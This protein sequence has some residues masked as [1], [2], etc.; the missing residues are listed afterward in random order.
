MCRFVLYQG[1]PLTIAS[2]VTEPANSI[3]NQSVHSKESEEPLNGDGFGVAWWA[4]ELSHKPAVFRSV[5]PAWSNM[6]LLELA[7][8]TRSGSIL[9]HVRA[10]TRGL[11]VT[12]LNCHPFAA[13]PYAFMHNGDVAR[14]GAIRRRVLAD[15]SDDSFHAVKGSTDSEHLFGVFL[16]QVAKAGGTPAAATAGKVKA[17]PGQ[18]AEAM[19][20]GLERTIEYIT[21][22]SKNAAP[23]TKRDDAAADE[24]EDC[25]LNIAVSDGEHAVACRYTTATTDPSSLYVHTGRRYVCEGGLCRMVSPE[26]GHG[27]VIVSSEPLS[28]DPGWQKIP[29]NHM[30]VVGQDRTCEIRAMSVA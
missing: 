24:E 1:V 16:D 12:E 6:N 9:A 11:P 27:A 30:V 4:P 26:K 7:R 5:S 10:A 14:F 15:L 17:S 29:R 20:T 13:G 25:Y 3:I 21:G 22:L 18:Q 23:Q 28:D 8:V 2:L 19:A